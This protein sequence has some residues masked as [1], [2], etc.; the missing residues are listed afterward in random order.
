MAGHLSSSSIDLLQ[1]LGISCLVIKKIHLAINFGKLGFFGDIWG[2]GGPA[3]G[4]TGGTLNFYSI[5][6]NLLNFPHVDEHVTNKSSFF[7]F[8]FFPWLH[9]IYL[10]PRFLMGV[11][12]CEYEASGPDCFCRMYG[13][14]IFNTA[15]RRD[16]M[17]MGA[18][19][20]PYETKKCE[21][22]SKLSHFSIAIYFC[23]SDFLCG[24]FLLVYAIKRIHFK[25]NSRSFHS[26]DS[27][28]RGSR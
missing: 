9:Y 5:I 22:I 17:D 26:Q 13:L 1:L 15:N 14:L 10:Q 2:D 24:R 25:F 21:N 19:I 11:L 3:L 7:F 18:L 27:A 4:C 6:I 12:F 20:S 28:S 8:F 16:I 23:L